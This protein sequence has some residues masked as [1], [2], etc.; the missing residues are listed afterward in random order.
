MANT[1]RNKG[2]NA[3]RQYANEFKEMGY[4]LCITSRY[5]SRQHDDCGVDLI[6]IPFNVQIKAGKQ[7]AMKPYKE[8]R[9]MIDNLTEKIPSEVHKPCIVIHKR[10][11][12]RGHKS[13][14]EHEIVSMTFEDFKK[15]IKNYKE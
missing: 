7:R 5:G 3:E 10:P 13:K 1:N 11:V 2:H 8:I 9:N 14:P 4:S 15:I 6:N 12:G